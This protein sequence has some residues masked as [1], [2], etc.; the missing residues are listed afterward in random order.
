M[1]SSGHIFDVPLFCCVMLVVV[2]EMGVSTNVELSA[3]QNACC[4]LRW[5]FLFQDCPRALA[6]SSVRLQLRLAGKPVVLGSWAELNLGPLLTIE[7]LM[8]SQPG[9]TAGLIRRECGLRLRAECATGDWAFSHLP[10][11][12]S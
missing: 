8:V 10:S 2:Q 12:C 3:G 5:R 6:W 1:V 7:N 4:V 9:T 11:M